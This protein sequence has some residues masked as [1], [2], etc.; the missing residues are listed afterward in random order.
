M[1]SQIIPTSQSA[2]TSTDP[3]GLQRRQILWRMTQQHLFEVYRDFP[4]TAGVYT[5]PIG[6]V[7]PQ[8]IAAVKLAKS[9]IEEELMKELLPAL[10]AWLANPSLENT[11]EIL[12]GAVDSV[13]VIFQLMYSMDLPF[14]KAFAEVHASN[15]AKLQ[16][17][18]S[19]NLLKR[20]DGKILKPANWQPPQLFNLLLNHANMRAVETSSHGAE[21]WPQAGDLATTQEP[22]HE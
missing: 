4:Q 2:I 11:V 19:G 14:T 12:D 5:E 18:E 17:D 21:N 6:G 22:S 15:M 3:H 16:L 9:L 20:A 1:T 7:S 10:D 13:Y 8:L